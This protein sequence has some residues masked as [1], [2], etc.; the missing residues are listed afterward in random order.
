MTTEA[1]V[2]KGAETEEAEEG[3]SERGTYLGPATC[4]KLPLSSSSGVELS[5]RCLKVTLAPLLQLGGLGY[6]DA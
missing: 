4:Q 6:A 3:L 2:S 1:K 5:K